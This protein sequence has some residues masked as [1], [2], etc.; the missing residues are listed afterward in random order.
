LQ[1][2][3]GDALLAEELAW[4]REER[5][6]LDLV[7]F[8]ASELERLLA[9]ADG[10]TAPDDAED[11]VPEPPEDAVSKPGDLWVLGN[12]RVL[13]GDATALADVERVLGGQLADMVFCDPPYGVNYASS[14]KDRLR[15]K[16]R[17]IL[18]DNLGAGFEA[19][20]YD[21]CVNILQVT[22][23]AVYVC[24][25]SS[26]LDMGDAERVGVVLT[27][28]PF[29]GEEEPGIQNNFPGD[30]RTAETALLFMQ[31]VMRRLKRG[32][33]GRCGIVVPNG[34]LFGDGVC[35]KIKADLIERFN[36]H[37]VVRLPE[38]VFAPYT[39][40]PTNLLFF[41][42]GGPTEETWIYEQPLP[43][44]RRKYSKTKPLRFEEFE[45]LIA[46][47]RDRKPTG[48]AWTVRPR[49]LVRRDEAGEVKALN[50]D[51]R[52]PNV[53]D[54]VDDRTPEQLVESIIAK[55]KR[56]LAMMEEIR[57][58]LAEVA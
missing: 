22:K 9:L 30:R 55:Q 19:F 39:D 28:P 58:T 7:G 40:I 45:D 42:S 2:G 29:G 56:V 33:A 1:A 10:D 17:P 16:H 11:E 41:Q 46:W 14:P 48:R 32:G 57:V 12:H 43:E 24:M 38:G 31:V 21:A 34:F 35:A 50:L 27:N 13:C 26:E 54:E 37:L 20:L 8:D 15:G 47:S 49:E 18:N 5:F 44:G 53:K 4:L 3:W 51:L 52:N 6:D 23:G 25:S 36:L